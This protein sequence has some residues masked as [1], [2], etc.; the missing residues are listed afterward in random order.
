MLQHVHEFEDGSES[1]K[2]IG[3]YSTLRRAGAAKKRLSRQPGFCDL[4]QG[5]TIDEYE[6][7]QDNWTEGFV[8]VPLKKT[9]A[10]ARSGREYPAVGSANE[11]T[12][13]PPTSTSTQTRGGA[14]RR[15]ERPG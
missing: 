11:A 6:V 14:R 4:P 1:V 15:P 9:K 3:V 5:F 7:D 2:L 13:R 8:T 12:R 10:R